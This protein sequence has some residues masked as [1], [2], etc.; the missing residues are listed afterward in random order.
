MNL[1]HTT[2]PQLRHVLTHGR[3]FTPSV[4][5]LFFGLE[6]FGRR[7]T[8]DVHDTVGA[9]VLLLIL[10]GLA[11]R[12]GAHPL[13][14]V[15]GF[16]PIPWFVARAGDRFKVDVGPDLGGLPPIPRRLPA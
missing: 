1:F 3:W 5:I 7:A 8:S 14:W 15:K 16:G 2:F 4:V 13:L 6:M 12:P 10:V 11:L 9:A